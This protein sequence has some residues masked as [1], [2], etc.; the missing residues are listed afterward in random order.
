MTKTF[1]KYYDKAM[2]PLEKK[3]ICD[4]VITIEPNPHMIEKALVR[5]QQASVPIQIIE[6]KAKH[7]PFPNNHFD[8]I[9]ITL[10]LC[11]VDNMERVLQECKR[12][13]KPNGKLLV[14]EHIKMEQP[15][16][17]GLQHLL[18]PAWKHIADGCH[19][20]RNPEVLI[21]ECGFNIISSKK[22][23]S[24]FVISLIARS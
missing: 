7:L 22:Y 3:Y 1:A 6:N 10:V 11:S 20:N 15:F 9:V 8:T 13:L 14:S 23:L 24:S 21:E 18:T 4:K 12:V 19:L 2:T 5:E 17:A 16:C